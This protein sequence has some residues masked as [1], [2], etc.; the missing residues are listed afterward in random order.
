[1]AIIFKS[2]CVPEWNRVKIRAWPRVE[3]RADSKEMSERPGFRADSRITASLAS[4]MR[5]SS[6]E[7]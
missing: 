6:A 2:I 5:G 4:K 1:M 7:Q 3:E